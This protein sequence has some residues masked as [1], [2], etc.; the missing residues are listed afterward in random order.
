MVRYVIDTERDPKTNSPFTSG[1]FAFPKYL[2]IEATDEQAKS[3]FEKHKKSGEDLVLRRRWFG[4]MQGWFFKIPTKE[5][6]VLEG[7][8][9]IEYYDSSQELC[10]F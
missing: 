2:G 6:Y 5:S 8:G 7:F 9:N 1:V 4:T 3:Y 10:N